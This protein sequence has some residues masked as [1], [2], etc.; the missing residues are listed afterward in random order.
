[1][2]LGLCNAPATFQRSMNHVLSTVLGEKALV[3]LDDIV[4]FS[5]TPE[6]H[7][8][9]LREVLT[10][11][12]KAGLKIKLQKCK[13]MKKSVEFLGHIISGEGISPNPSTIKAIVNYAKPTSVDEVRSFLRPGWLL[14]AI[15]TALRQ[16]CQTFNAKNSQRRN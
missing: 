10:L 2:P 15:H 16:H 8:I 13:F 3:Y 6:N 11:L 9:N 7:L 1:M 14:Q 5:D 12:K 4:V